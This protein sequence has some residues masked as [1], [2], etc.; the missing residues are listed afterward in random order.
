MLVHHIGGGV[1]GGDDGGG[2]GGGAGGG[3][4]G[5]KKRRPQSVQSVPKAHCAGVPCRSVSEP[6]P[7]SWHAPLLAASVHESSHAMGGGGDEGGGGD[8][9]GGGGDGGNM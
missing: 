3:D 8:G 1:D 5:G 2:E 4:G 9:D 7:P 6:R